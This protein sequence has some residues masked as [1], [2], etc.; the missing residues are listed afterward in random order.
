M[1]GIRYFYLVKLPL[2]SAMLVLVA[3][4]IFAKRGWMDWQ[5]MVRQNSELSAKIAGV[6]GQK[7]DLEKQLIALRSDAAEQERVIRQT[8]GYVKPNE[9]VIEFP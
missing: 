4:G 5:R 3:M 9:T 8:L 6:Q 7:A 2:F 1:N